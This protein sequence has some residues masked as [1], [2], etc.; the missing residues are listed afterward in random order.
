V[1]LVV[2]VVVVS[3]AVIL[4]NNIDDDLLLEQMQSG[5]QYQLSGVLHKRDDFSRTSFPE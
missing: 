2:V 3:S 4:N 5:E 1:T